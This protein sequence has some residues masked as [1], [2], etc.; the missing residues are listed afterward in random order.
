MN[1]KWKN[2]Q[3]LFLV[4]QRSESQIMCRVAST[5]LSAYDNVT[6]KDFYSLG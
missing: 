1:L 3:Y 5:L 6:Q 4:Q 2:E